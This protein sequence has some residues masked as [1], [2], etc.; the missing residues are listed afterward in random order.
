MNDELTPGEIGRT[1]QRLE[2]GQNAVLARLEVLGQMFVTRAEWDMMRADLNQRRVPWTA[3]ASFVVGA[4]A[5]TITLVQAL[6]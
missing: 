3:V 5:L 6:G 1:L 4:A 2:S